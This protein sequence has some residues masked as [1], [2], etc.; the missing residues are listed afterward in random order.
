MP[1]VTRRT[2]AGLAELVVSLALAGV[3][4]A[5][6]SRSVVQQ[7]RLH[8]ERD[9]QAQADAIVREVS[10]VL[11]A[12]IGH[13][14]AAVRVLGDTAIE[15][16]SQRIAASACEQSAARLVVPSNA[17]WWSAPHAG[18]SVALL[19]TLARSEWHAAIVAT[20]TQR[21]TAACPSGGTRLT[22][23]DLPPATVPSI[24][25]PV[26]VW[27]ILRYMVYRASDN[28]WWL[29]ERACAPG[30]GSAQPIAGPLLPPS[31]RGFRVAFVLRGD[32]QPVAIDL[33]LRAIIGGRT[34]R[35]SARLPLVAAP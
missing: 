9:A 17:A 12:E 20:G 35:L 10:E 2:G 14:D 3:V 7:L 22:L 31:Q 4:M 27:R 18:D 29:G 21:A 8:R 15:L 25:V 23:S 33:S 5:T 6:A 1:A 19:D 11:R 30:C 28:T 16:A 32:A 24:Q 13:A 26:R 34:A